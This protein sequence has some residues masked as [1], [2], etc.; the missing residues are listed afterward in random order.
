M[1]TLKKL[2]LR[3]ASEFF[4]DSE[5]KS[6]VGGKRDDNCVYCGDQCQLY[7]EHESFGWIWVNGYCGRGFPG[8]GGNNGPWLCDYCNINPYG[9]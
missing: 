3:N 1:R 5:L 2:R 4:S 6:V 7:I 9:W 8:S